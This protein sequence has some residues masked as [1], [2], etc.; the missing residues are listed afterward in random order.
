M[1][2]TPYTSP[3]PVRRAHLGDAVASE[4]TKMRSLRSTVWTL[5][6]MVALVAG[7]GVVLAFVVGEPLAGEQRGEGAV[8]LLSLP[9]TLLA[10]VCV[11]TLGAL[12]ITSEF[13]T[14]LIRTTLTACPSRGRVLTAK[15]LVFSGLVFTTTTLVAALTTAAQCAILGTTDGA[16]ADQWA[17]AT[18]GVG[19]FMACLGLLSLAVGALLRHSAGSITTVIG[20]VLLPYV[21]MIG[22]YAE[23]LEGL[24]NA[25]VE[26]S[27]PVL[28]GTLYTGD[29]T[30][31]MSGPSGWEA[32]WIMAGL[33][34]AALG[35]A[36]AAFGRRDA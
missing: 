25:L 9:G 10:T 33:A 1:T 3:I 23:E 31:G 34:A 15:A 4:W 13:G 32:L 16:T 5:G 7:L 29:P 17:R 2:T 6:V 8:L 26:Y 24:R 12:T 36:Y 35:G 14:G 20:L 19:L 11:I 18:V 22:L 21:L 27:L 28:L 30:G